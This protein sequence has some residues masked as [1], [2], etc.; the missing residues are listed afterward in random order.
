MSWIWVVMLIIEILMPGVMIYTGIMLRI[1][2]PSKGDPLGYR[3]ASARV[4]RQTWD[5]AQKVYSI[6]SII[7]GAMCIIASIIV[8]IIFLKKDNNGIYTVTAIVAVASEGLLLALSSLLT[9]M[10]ISIKF[11]ND[12]HIKVKNKKKKSA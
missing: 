12:G 1:K 3:G 7:L 5:Y 11:D 6:I 8:M 10:F 4:N 2:K 9:S